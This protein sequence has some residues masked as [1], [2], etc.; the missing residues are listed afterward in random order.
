MSSSIKTAK[1]S[2]IDL[3]RMLKVLVETTMRSNAE[4]AAEQQM[5]LAATADLANSR[6]AGYNE[7]AEETLTTMDGLRGIILDQILPAVITIS[8]RQD[9]TEKVSRSCL[10][11]LIRCAKLLKKAEILNANL[12]YMT[13]VISNHTEAIEQASLYAKAIS[14]TFEKLAKF[15]NLWNDMFNLDGPAVTWM[16][17]IGSPYLCLFFGTRG[18]PS[19]LIR[20]AILLISGYAFAEIILIQLQPWNWNSGWVWTLKN[21]TYSSVSPSSDPQ[22]V[23][24][25]LL[26]TH[27][28]FELT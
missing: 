16:L 21:W 19:S 26:T 10:D 7:M 14:Q 20:N 24:E 28:D 1:G 18:I 15:A 12:D 9:V 2:T 11:A 22:L 8:E 17:R 3:Q 5:A 25:P 4:L 6:M 23:L 13:Y 27:V